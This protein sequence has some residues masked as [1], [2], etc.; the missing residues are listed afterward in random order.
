VA[1]AEK[2]F[3]YPGNGINGV[4]GVG[5]GCARWKPFQLWRSSGRPTGRSHR[6]R[7]RADERRPLALARGDTDRLGVTKKGLM[8]KAQE[9]LS[10]KGR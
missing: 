10:G 7:V 5:R 1:R 4:R 6:T 9:F 3:S 8:I 2:V